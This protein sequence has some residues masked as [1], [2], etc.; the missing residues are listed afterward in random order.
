MSPVDIATAPSPW[1]DGERAIQQ[2]VG[3]RTGDDLGCGRSGV[4]AIDAR[5][6]FA[7]I[8]DA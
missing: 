5:R 2:R 1:H 7:G 8:G 6:H 4:Q 3:E